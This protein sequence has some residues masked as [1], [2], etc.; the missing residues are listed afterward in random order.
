MPRDDRRR[1]RLTEDSADAKS[2]RLVL[3]FIYGDWKIEALEFQSR[4]QGVI[5]LCIHLFNLGH[6]F[7]V[8]RMVRY[9]MRHL[10][11]HLS[12]KLKEMC[13]YPPPK[14]LEAAERPDFL[15]DLEAGIN[16]AETAQEG[17]TP[18]S[19]QNHPRRM[20]IDFVVAAGPVLLRAAPFRMTVD[21][22][23]RL[24]AAFIKDVLLGTY[25]REPLTTWMKKLQVR[26]AR[27]EPK[28]RGACFG[29]GVGVARGQAAVF[30][31][32]SEPTFEQRYPQFCCEGCAQ[33]MDEADGRGVKWEIFDDVKEE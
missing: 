33:H 21:E 5:Q 6:H 22:D 20:L 25:A 27:P 24:P 13:V 1:P 4:N 19:Q 32:W 9:A 18:F 3:E 23:N 2:V 10:G 15:N 31:P 26:P 14:G 30:N 7:G 17:A 28:K 29:C 16:Q 8:P 11:M 12:S